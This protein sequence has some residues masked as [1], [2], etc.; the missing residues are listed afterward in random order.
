[1]RKA[2][3][4]GWALRLV[5]A[6]NEGNRVEDSRVELKGEL[7]SAE[8]A[9]RRMAG[10]ANAARNDPILWVIGLDEVR[11]VV[12]F[13]LPDF[14][15]WGQQLKS[16]FVGPAPEW[17]EV[18]VP[19]GTA[20]V[21]ALYID[22][23]QPPYMVKNP[24]HGKKGGGPVEVEV[25]WREGTI[26]RTARRENLLRILLSQESVPGYEV[27]SAD[28]S[29]HDYGPGTRP[30]G[31]STPPVEEHSSYWEVWATIYVTPAPR[32]QL[33]YPAHLGTV[34]IS[35]G[36]IEGLNFDEV[37]FDVPSRHRFHGY[38]PEIDSHTVRATG[39]ELIV[40]G[41]GRFLLKAY[42]LERNRAKPS[43]RLQLK[44]ALTS[45]WGDLPLII[46]AQLEPI[47]DR[48]GQERRWKFGN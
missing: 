27:L 6:V 29:L 43:G 12:P 20:R 39:S 17:Q 7:P 19:V 26:A 2:D 37:A 23:S 47:P 42:L 34:E 18:L 44:V 14:A 22:T 33:V 5:E 8:Q 32:R 24:A 30:R 1:M 48:S 35:I 4:E 45:A 38:A 10:H 31:P 13:D 9:A 3:I 36:Q 28:A 21:L 16:Y 46:E 25:P 40:D 41:P 11:G 15:D